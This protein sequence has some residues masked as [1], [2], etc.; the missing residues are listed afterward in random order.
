MYLAA[1]LHGVHYPFHGSHKTVMEFALALH[2]SKL[3]L[4]QHTS[5]SPTGSLRIDFLDHFLGMHWTTIMQ[6]IL[7]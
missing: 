2:Q 4:A 6:T 5:T 1:W 7:G 3:S